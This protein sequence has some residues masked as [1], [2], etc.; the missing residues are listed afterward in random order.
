MECQAGFTPW[1]KL[2]SHCYWYQR[3]HYNEL[4][5]QQH[6]NNDATL[7]RTG[8]NMSR[9]YGREMDCY[10]RAVAEKLEDI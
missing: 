4:H 5:E 2:H 9:I 10:M 3:E 1:A 7:V 8:K 6:N